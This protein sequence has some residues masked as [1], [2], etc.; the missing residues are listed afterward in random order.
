MTQGSRKFHV[1]ERGGPGQESH[2]TSTLPNA[3]SGSDLAAQQL[4]K[5]AGGNEETSQ[6]ASLLVKFTAL[7][8]IKRKRGEQK[9][10]RV[11]E[12]SPSEQP[13]SKPSH[14]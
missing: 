8:T 6:A 9:G 2:Q 14:P 4:A 3:F 11:Q 10:K 12:R 7:L 13:L 1:R 5:P